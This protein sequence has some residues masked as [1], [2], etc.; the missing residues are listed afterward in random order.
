MFWWCFG[1]HLGVPGAQNANGD[2]LGNIRNELATSP[3]SNE[4]DKNSQIGKIRQYR[5]NEFI[6]FH[7]DIADVV[8]L[9]CL[10]SAGVKGGA[11]RLASS[12]SVFNELRKRRPDLVPLLFQPT[13]LDTRGDGGVNWFNVI[14]SRYFDSVLRTFWH[15]EYFMTANRYKSSP[16]GPSLA[17]QDLVRVYDEI[18]NDPQFYLETEFLEGDIQLISNHVVISYFFAFQRLIKHNLITLYIYYRSFI[19]EQ[20]SKTLLSSNVTCCVCGCLLNPQK[21]AGLGINLRRWTR[22]AFL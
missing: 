2:L 9:I 17:M 3:S 8:G 22:K 10:N 15:T 11:S 18:A 7:C 14:P 16:V 5:T 6:P 13:P 21:F 20:P 1:Q 19:L 12:V 4:L